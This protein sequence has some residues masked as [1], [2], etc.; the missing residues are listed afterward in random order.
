MNGQKKLSRRIRRIA[1]SLDW[2]VMEYGD[3]TVE[4]RQSS[5]AGEDFSFT[6]SIEKAESEIYSYYSFFDADEHIEMWVKARS[7]GV[8]GIP[9]IRTLVED[10]D[11]IEEMLEALAEAVIKRKK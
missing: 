9:S 4:F 8:S 7:N 5:P 2:T 11:A 3:G 1:E 6:V 10:A